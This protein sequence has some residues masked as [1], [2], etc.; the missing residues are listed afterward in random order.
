MGQGG[1][2][3]KTFHGRGMYRFF[4]WNDTCHQSIPCHY[5]H[6]YIMLK[7]IHM[8]SIL[9][10]TLNRIFASSMLRQK[11]KENKS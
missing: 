10:T 3:Q 4:C 11:Q 5:A 2:L 6:L 8:L 1:Q 7:D 9:H